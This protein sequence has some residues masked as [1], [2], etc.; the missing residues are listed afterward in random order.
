MHTMHL[1]HQ[2]I[3]EYYRPVFD[4]LLFPNGA[5]QNNGPS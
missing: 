3:A 1:L 2:S 4:A 5:G